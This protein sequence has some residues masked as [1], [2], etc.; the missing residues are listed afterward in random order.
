METLMWKPPE[1]WN[2]FPKDFFREAPVGSYQFLQSQYAYK[3][4]SVEEL[5]KS[6]YTI[7]FMQEVYLNSSSD[8]RIITR[9]LCE[10]HV[11]SPLL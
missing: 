10:W 8:N 11:N 1:T 2:N 4:T 9:G 6:L 7:K 3:A 5:S